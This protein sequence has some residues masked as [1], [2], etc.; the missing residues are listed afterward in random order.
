MT[1][2]STKRELENL[3]RDVNRLSE[4]TDRV[5]SKVTELED[6]YEEYTEKELQYIDKYKPMT[7]NTMEDED[8]YDII[9][10]YNFDDNKIKQELNEYIKLVKK[11][12]DE[13]G[14]TKI[15]KGKSKFN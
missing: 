7:D 12:G 14:W 11:K 2:K 3:N 15:E 13:Y 10:K 1:N 4:R 8:L 6:S 9:I 5:L